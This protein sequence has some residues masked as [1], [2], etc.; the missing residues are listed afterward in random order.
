MAG[1][2]AERTF[3]WSTATR[4][5]TSTFPRCSRSI[6]V[7]ALRHDGADSRTRPGQVCGVGLD[8]GHASRVSLAGL[9]TDTF[10]FIGPQIVEADVFETLPD[11]VPAESV[12]GVYPRLVAERPGAVM[13]YVSAATFRDIGTPADLL[14]TSL[15]LAAADGRP[16]AP[17]WGRNVQVNP[18][19]R[20]S[21]SILW[22]DVTIGAGVTLTECIVADGV[23]IPDQASYTRCAIVRGGEGL[24]VANL[25]RDSE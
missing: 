14:Q 2:R 4:S 24:V 9:K 8:A 1:G 25:D 10:H 11:G 17:W 13:G 5:R 12:T 23:T 15:D 19:A 6:A 3:V 20:I 16:D 7:G 21:R 22:D 18:S